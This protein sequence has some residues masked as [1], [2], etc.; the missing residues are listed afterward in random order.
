[1]LLPCFSQAQRAGTHAA[2]LRTYVRPGL[3][4]LDEIGFLPLGPEDANLLFQAVSQLRAWLHRPYLAQES[5]G[6]GRDFSGDAV[7]ASAILAR[8]LHHS[9]TI[10]IRG[11]SYR[12]KD[13]MRA[14]L[15]SQ[16]K[17]VSPK[18]SHEVGTSGI[19]Q[20]PRLP[21]RDQRYSRFT[22]P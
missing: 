19:Q 14:G 12:L 9:S 17:L 11:Q 8:L 15:V 13:K 4:I 16:A 22:C 2:P 1:M 6:V 5:W 21:L 3:L 20:G 18:D 7:I 10:K